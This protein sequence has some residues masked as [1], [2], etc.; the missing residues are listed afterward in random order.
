MKEGKASRWLLEEVGFSTFG[1]SSSWDVTQWLEA[2]HHITGKLPWFPTKFHP[3]NLKTIKNSGDYF[4]SFEFH[5][6]D[7][8]HNLEKFGLLDKEGYDR[9]L[10]KGEFLGEVFSPSDTNTAKNILCHWMDPGTKYWQN[11]HAE[12]DAKVIKENGVSALYYDIS[13]C[14]GVLGSDRVDHNHPV[15]W[16]RWMVDNY[17]KVFLRTKQA[18]IKANRDVYV[19]L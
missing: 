11:F 3:Q 14:I 5:F 17:K 8:R 2:F 10:N 16:G 15:G 6:F 9:L 1:I 13:S 7:Y 18:A 12:R 19:P 4:G